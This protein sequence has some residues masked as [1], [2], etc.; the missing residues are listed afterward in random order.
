VVGGLA[1]K[2]V[3]ILAVLF[4]F[5]LGLW[6]MWVE[7]YADS[8]VYTECRD[9]VP[10]GDGGDIGGDTVYFGRVY[11]G[12]AII[13]GGGGDHISAESSGSGFV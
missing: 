6:V 4:V 3:P 7:G 11:S 1:D 12:F 8:A 13:T 9:D 5:S 2:V 10:G